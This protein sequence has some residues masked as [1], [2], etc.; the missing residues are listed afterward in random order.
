ML[1]F[2]G[3]A[4]GL[5]AQGQD[6]I[7]EAQHRTADTAAQTHEH[8]VFTKGIEQL[9]HK[10]ASV[11]LGGAQTLS[12]LAREEESR[13]K[14]IMGILCAH[15]REVTTEGE[16]QQAHDRAPSAEV[17]ATIKLL[18]RL[19]RAEDFASA[20]EGGGLD[21]RKAF[22][23]GVELEGALLQKA[24]FSGAQLQR[25][26]LTGAQ[27]QGAHL[28]ETRLAR[29]NL[30]DVLLSGAVL[31]GAKLQNTM[32][33]D[34]QMQGADLKDAWLQGAWLNEAKL[35]GADLSGARLQGARLTGA[36]LPGA[37]L[38]RAKLQGAVLAK[39]QLQGA[40]LTEAQLQGASLQGVCLQGVCFQGTLP[41][42]IHSRILAEALLLREEPPENHYAG[43][44]LH[45]AF[46]NW[47]SV[48][49]HGFAERLRERKGLE[50][51]LS[52]AIFSGGMTQDRVEGIE[53]LF[54]E[55]KGMKG[56]VLPDE[57]RERILSGLADHVDQEQGHEIPDGVATGVLKAE[58]VE[59]I[60]REYEG[61][62]R[63][64]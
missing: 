28:I 48:A 60:I 15:I 8:E 10:S 26:N 21:F 31:E 4:L 55:L 56:G 36:E 5:R 50:T 29:A 53:R 1:F 44:Q 11:R 61:A 24:D 59:A 47:E 16:Y 6:R 19:C 42:A 2:N 13:R 14:S 54:A 39:A 27:L 51:D 46:D 32:A 37:V 23:R 12:D 57:E 45:G 33:F 3:L 43:P 62:M 52:T 40:F 25:S 20:P 7:A 49:S 17:A 64:D 35:Q 34:A 41:D 63:E 58:E 9:G 22:L 38:F 18:K 30:A